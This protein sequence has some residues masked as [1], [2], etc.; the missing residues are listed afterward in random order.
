[1]QKVA[2]W[3]VQQRNTTIKFESANKQKTSSKQATEAS[4][5]S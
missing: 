1:M 5:S 3:S 2:V 4:F